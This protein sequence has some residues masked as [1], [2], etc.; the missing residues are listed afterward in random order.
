MV[1][2]PAEEG[3]GG[4]SG[5]FHGFAGNYNRCSGMSRNGP[6]PPCQAGLF[7]YS[8]LAVGAECGRDSWLGCEEW[9]CSSRR[10]SSVGTE[11]AT[12]ARTTAFKGRARPAPVIRVGSDAEE[13]MPGRKVAFLFL[14]PSWGFLLTKSRDT[15]VPCTH[16]PCKPATGQDR[17][18]D[19]GTGRSPGHGAAC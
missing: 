11:T 14:P 2:V 7:G 5:Q 16:G 12:P 1:L 15:G 17:G 13:P 6:C 4:L 9:V 3:D 19:R 10:E 8:V 18:G